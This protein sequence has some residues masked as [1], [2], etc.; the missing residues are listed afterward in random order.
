[1]LEK[2]PLCNGKATNLYSV[3][4]LNRKIT[5]NTFDYKSCSNC[6]TIFLT[7]IPDDLGS[8]YMGEYYQIPSKDNLIKLAKKN[9]HKINIINKYSNGTELLEIGPAFGM[10]S[11]LARM[12]DYTVDAIEQ[13]KKC[14]D[15]IMNDICRNVIHSNDPESELDKLG[16]Y[17]VIALWHVFEHM[18]N[19]HELL[20]KLVSKLKKNGIIVLAVP[21]PDSIQLKY[22]NKYWPHLD[23]PRHLQLVPI[24][25]FKKILEAEKLK[26]EKVIYNDKDGLRW[27]LFSWQRILMN[28]V[29]NNFLKK[30]AFVIGTFIGFFLLPVDLYKNK[31]AAYTA[32]FKKV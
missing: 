21:N 25:T 15:F 4:D 17:D 30:I 24:D 5:V 14:C 2:C 27:S 3:R 6:R 29:D 28:T 32:I 23:A 8:Y 13:D 9:S 10:F 1:M 31:A 20:V 11:K 19:P 22:M 26:L 7:N 16:N 12:N 18:Q